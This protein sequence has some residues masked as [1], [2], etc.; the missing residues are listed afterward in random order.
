MA[1]SVAELPRSGR[2][3]RRPQHTFQLKQTP[4]A[5]QPFLLAPVLPGETM[6]NLLMQA[7]VVT[8]PIKNPLVGWWIEYFFFYV[9]H[10]DLNIRDALTDMVLSPAWT[11]AGAGIETVPANAATYFCGNGIDWT[12]ACLERVVEEY[13]RNDGEA[14]DDFL[15][16]GLPAAS[17]NGNSWLDSVISRADYDGASGDDVT[18]NTADGLTASEVEGAMRMWDIMRANNLTQM[19]YEDFLRTYGVRAP[20]AEDP[21]RPELVRF[22][23]EWSYPTNTVNPA[24]GSPSSA[25]SWS[26]A[27]RA[28]K[29]RF[30]KEPG[31]L[32]GVSVARP[33]VYLSGQKGSAAWCMRNA[34]T[35]LPALLQGDPAASLTA[36]ADATGP[37]GDITDA[38]GY[39]VDVRDILLY[40][41][42]FLNFDPAA[43]GANA[44]ALPLPTAGLQKRYPALLADV[45]AL[46]KT[47]G[48]EKVRQD[49]VVSLTIAGSQ[50]DATP[51][52][53]RVPLGR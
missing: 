1:I 52:V 16:D 7:R 28:D 36:I 47:A 22:V 21:H 43:V 51:T 48:S 14:W 20:D 50:R 33:K 13:F 34:F 26:I 6:K 9:K 30:F 19:S 24:D 40:G 11:A 15:I 12:A 18:I 38:T 46:F 29:D 27:E 17:I 2:V 37:L 23:R 49:G 8:D 44:S 31:F 41:D 42:Q 53:N 39:V 5:I 25:V 3:T 10:R 35:W 32:F 45:Q 4:Y